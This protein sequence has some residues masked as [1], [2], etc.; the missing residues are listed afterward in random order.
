MEQ[1]LQQLLQISAKLYE[2]LISN[3]E[4]TKR[5]AFIEEINA[6]LDQRGKIMEELVQSGFAYNSGV[7]THQMLLELDKG[8]RNRL[9]RVM[10]SIKADMKELQTSKKS[11]QQYLNPYSHIQTMDGMYY[12]KKK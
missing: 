4:E 7:K 9:E 10:S 11:E 1:Q 5:D 2:K 8:I 3:P 12:D 6:L